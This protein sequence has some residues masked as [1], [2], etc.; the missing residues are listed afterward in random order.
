MY[1]CV[2][3]RAFFHVSVSSHM[4]ARGGGCTFAPLMREPRVCSTTTTPP[5]SPRRRCRR[6]NVASRIAQSRAIHCI[7]I[8]NTYECV[9]VC[10]S[11]SLR[12][13]DSLMCV[14]VCSLRAPHTYEYIL[15]LYMK[16]QVNT[17]ANAQ[18]Y[19]SNKNIHI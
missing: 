14:C 5:T 8:V 17:P 18:T 9:C 19:I 4:C 6:A 15:Y 10:F 3:V 2:C 7:H 11:L 13:R 16:S 12:A 1:M